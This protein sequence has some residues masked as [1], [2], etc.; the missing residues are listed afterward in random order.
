VQRE[1]LREEL[2]S[3]VFYVNCLLGILLTAIAYFGSPLAAAFFREP[4]LIP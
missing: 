3:S 1:E 4:Q 2:T